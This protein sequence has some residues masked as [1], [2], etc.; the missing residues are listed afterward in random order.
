VCADVQETFQDAGSSTKQGVQDFF[1]PI[2]EAGSSAVD[3]FQG[4]TSDVGEGISDIASSAGDALGLSGGG[5][6]GAGEQEDFATR[7]LDLLRADLGPFRELG[8]S[9]IESAQ[10]LPYPQ[11]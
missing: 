1:N 3:Q 6:V 10:A 11:G 2:Q 9:Q 5:G 4:L 7:A 8:A